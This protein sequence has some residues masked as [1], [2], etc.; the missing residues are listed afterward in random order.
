MP[1]PKLTHTEWQSQVVK[2]AGMLGWQHLHVRRAIGRGK[3]WVTATNLIGWPDLFLFAPG[4]G[5]VAI[6]LKVPPDK[7]TV[8]QLGILSSL[9]LAGARTLVAYPDDLEAVRDLLSRSTNP[10]EPL[11]R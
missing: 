8:E 11:Y 4:R 2:L 10:K 5:F 6:E 7:A 3:R 1:A 9:E